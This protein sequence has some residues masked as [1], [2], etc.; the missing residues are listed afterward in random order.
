MYDLTFTTNLF[1]VTIDIYEDDAK[2][3][4]NFENR[5]FGNPRQNI[6][7]EKTVAAPPLTSVISDKAVVSFR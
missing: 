7:N 5:E 4:G 6:H 3:N 2:I 1:A